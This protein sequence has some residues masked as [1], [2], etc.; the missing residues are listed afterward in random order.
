MN[1]YG[2]AV[3]AGIVLLWALIDRILIPFWARRTGAR[4]AEN[5][6]KSKAATNPRCLEDPKYGSLVG[7]IDCLRITS[8][9][10]EC[11][12]LP[13]GEVEEV[14][15]Y[16]VDLYTTDLICLA[17]K[18]SGTNAYYEINEEMSGYH[19]LLE[20]LPSRLP[21]FTMAWLLTSPAFETK[22]HI[23]WRRSE[24]PIAD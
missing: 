13:W 11:A 7:G 19:D 15:G 24:K 12:E 10:G 20:M 8:R 23:I 14:L 4:I 16:R 17:F 5:L 18:K 3:V 21:K 1:L 9:N 22:H 6:L 2:I